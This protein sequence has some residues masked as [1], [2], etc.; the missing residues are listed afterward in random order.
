MIILQVMWLQKPKG[1]DYYVKSAT[2][3]EST[4]IQCMYSVLVIVG[5]IRV[6]Q[7][8]Q[9][10]YPLFILQYLSAIQGVSGVLH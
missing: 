7:G 9:L 4:A 6:Q 10:R 2:L 5:K 8:F 1:V 3:L